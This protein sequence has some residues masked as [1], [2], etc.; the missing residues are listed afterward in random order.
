[1]HVCSPEG[2]CGQVSAELSCSGITPTSPSLGRWQ[3]IETS[4]NAL[5]AS[6]HRWESKVQLLFNL[7]NM[8]SLAI[9]QPGR[10]VS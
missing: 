9:K 3:W 2:P 4:Y 5:Q 1:M 6:M 7:D 10:L 8:R